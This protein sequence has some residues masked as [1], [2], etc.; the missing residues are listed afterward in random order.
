VT[1]TILDASGVGP[2]GITR[3]LTEVVR[4]WPGGHRLAVVAAPAGWSPPSDVDIVSRQRS[5]RSRTVVAARRDLSRLTSNRGLVPADRV[6]STDGGRVL[7]LSPSLAIAG[8][9]WPVTTLVHDVAFRLWPDGLS[10]TVRSYRRASYLGALRDS[11]RILCVSDRT[12]HD[13]LG[14]FGFPYGRS[15]VWVP[16]SDLVGAGGILPAPLAEVHARGGQYLLVPGHA[17]HKGVD[18]AL[19][20]LP[21]LPWYTLAILMGGRRERAEPQDRVVRLDQLTDADYV[22][23]VAGAAVFLMPSHFEGYGL[24][25]VEALRLGTRTVI[26]PDAALHEA[27]EGRA[28]RMANWTAGA[29]VRAVREAEGGGAPAVPAGRTWAEATQDLY[30]RL[31]G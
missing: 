6:R 20:A 14:L 30:G 23:T 24:P 17:P 9:R 18:L 25:A 10:R 8:S 22:A 13:L 12:R 2:G 29:L 28:A 15:E 21:E 19:E 16:G 31:Y 1:T 27:T 4:H 26:S 5:S 7:S 3:V 11:E